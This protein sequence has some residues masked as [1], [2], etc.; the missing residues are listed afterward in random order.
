MGPW[1]AVMLELVYCWGHHLIGSL[2]AAGLSST[3]RCEILWCALFPIATP[4]QLR[5]CLQNLQCFQLWRREEQM[6]IV[7]GA[8]L[9]EKELTSCRNS[10]NYAMTQNS[11]L[12]EAYDEAVY[13]DG[14][15][16]KRA[17]RFCL[18]AWIQ[19]GNGWS[20]GDR[21]FERDAR[22]YFFA[23]SQTFE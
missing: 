11:K 6:Q 10:M 19:R 5:T 9:S 2:N 8:N 4:P 22:T 15:M 7:D 14:K 23:S 21:S 1:A 17:S 16:D 18:L 3:P 20:F 12:K 13:Q